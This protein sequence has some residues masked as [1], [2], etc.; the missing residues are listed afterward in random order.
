MMLLMNKLPMLCALGVLSVLAGAFALDVT[1][2]QVD[3]DEVSG[4][5]EKA[6]SGA[7]TVAGKAIKLDDVSEVRVSGAAQPALPTKPRIILRNGDSLYGNIVEGGEKGLKIKQEVLGELDIKSNAL[8]GIV[9]P[10]RSAA[11]EA[12]LDAFFAKEGLNEDLMLTPKGESVGGFMEKFTDTE[13]VIEV[14]EQKRTLTYEQIA[15]FRFATTEKPVVPQGVQ[16]A[17]RL[18]DGSVLS[19]V[20]EGFGGGK[21]NLKNADGALWPVPEKALYAIGIRGGKL[22]FLSDLKAQAEEKPLVGGMPVVRRWRLNAAVTGEGLKIGRK[23]YTRGLG[24]HSWC[25]LTYDLGGAYSTFMAE[26]GLD[27]TAMPSA[28]C[29]YQ[30]LGDGKELAAGEARAGEAPKK[31]KIEVKGVK[32]LELICDFGSDNDDAGDHFNWAEARLVK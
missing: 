15:A 16:V 26:V 2:V 20:L 3:G 29:A 14:G 8:R 1:V 17:L 31:I 30:V 12:V 24:V 11:A 21:L 23:E 22:V 32:A 5:L 13:L 4:A 25:K 7:I 6:E 27:N 28:A 10:A 9:F 19:G 18:C